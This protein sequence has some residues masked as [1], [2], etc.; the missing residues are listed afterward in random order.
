MSYQ[1]PVAPLYDTLI[2]KIVSLDHMS[3]L[4][5]LSSHHEG[6]VGNSLT[7]SDHDE[8]QP[9][10]V[11]PPIR[12]LDPSSLLQVMLSHRT[13]TSRFFQS[14]KAGWTMLH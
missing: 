13:R 5:R 3:T 6:G 2:R 7:V 9:Q 10:K 1:S 8:Q 11:T 4:L 14:K 12:L